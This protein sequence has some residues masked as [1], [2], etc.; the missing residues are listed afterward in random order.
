MPGNGTL[1]CSKAT[2][3]KAALNFTSSSLAAIA[4]SFDNAFCELIVVFKH[5]RANVMCLRLMPLPFN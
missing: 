4:Y 5:L 2:V 3:S 1:F